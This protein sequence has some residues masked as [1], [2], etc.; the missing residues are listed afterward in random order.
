MRLSG[1]VE[2]DRNACN[3]R[4]SCRPI[5]MTA[6]RGDSKA[7]TR[8]DDCGVVGDAA[9]FAGFSGFREYSYRD[10]APKPIHKLSQVDTH[11]G[12]SCRVS[13]WGDP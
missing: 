1:R 10:D 6:S 7:I 12:T 5:A 4:V 8:F 3:E 13:A 11:F 2:K 9:N